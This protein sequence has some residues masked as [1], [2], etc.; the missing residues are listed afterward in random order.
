[1]LT[2]LH[3]LREKYAGPEGYVQ[4]CCGLSKDDVEIIRRNLVKPAEP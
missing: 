2:F 3:M 1:M 4:R